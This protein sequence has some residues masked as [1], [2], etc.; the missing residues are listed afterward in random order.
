M[1]EILYI[2][3]ALGLTIFFHELGHFLAARALG[4]GV[5]SFSI[6]F[7]PKLF[8]FKKGET[9]YL[10]CALVFLGGYVKL[11]GENPEELNPNDKK[12]FLNQHP[13]KKI[14]IASSGVIQNIF[15]AFLLMWLVFTIGTDTLKP[16]IG[17][18]K[19]GYPAY[20]AGLQKG[21]EIININGKK[22]KY[23]SEVTDIVTNFSGKELNIV[24]LRGGKELLFNIKPKIE[25][26]EDILKDKKKRP[27]IGISPLAFLPVVD[28]VKKGYPAYEAG[29]KKGDVILEI[30]GKKITYWDEVTDIIEKSK[31]TLKIKIKRDNEIKEFN[32][33]STAIPPLGAGSGGLIWEK[34]K[35]IIQKKLQDL[36]IEIFIYEPTSEIKE[37]LKKE[38][39]KLTEA[40]AL[41]LYVLYDL[42]KQGEFVS[43]FSAEKVCYFLQKFGAEKYFKLKYQPNFY[44]PY[45]G[46]VKFLLNILNGSYILGYSDLNKK[47]FDPLF[48]IPDSYNEIKKYVE[49]K[50][51]LNNIAQKTINFLDGFYSD[52]GLELLS[53]ID[54]IINEKK[55]T[56]IDEIKKELENWSNR[57][58]SLFSNQKY[59]QIAIEHIKNSEILKNF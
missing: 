31:D 28:D 17:E 54:W 55:T 40:R 5:T 14:I 7:G 19:K 10:I 22:I 44:G 59:I 37:Q 12:A 6:G 1:L 49:S 21:D 15:L 34:V 41:M 9:E 32:I 35:N 38:R 42:V 33:K 18:V 8:S 51:E 39:A 4:V 16:T 2:I 57:K 3:I 46:K 25:E 45:S 56:D 13:I 26:A 48:I 50:S 30:S 47:P 43:E 27:F 53:T 36:D 29:L 58:R 23:W 24:V 52:F 11:Q 20:D